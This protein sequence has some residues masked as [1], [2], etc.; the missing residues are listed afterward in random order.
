M[1]GLIA[2]AAVLVVFLSMIRVIFFD[3]RRDED[4]RDRRDRDIDNDHYYW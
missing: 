1:G 2:V 4:Q 3:D